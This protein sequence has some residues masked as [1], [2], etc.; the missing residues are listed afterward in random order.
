MARLVVLLPALNEAGNI[1]AVVK[2]VLAL[3]FPGIELS[4]LVVDD[5]SSDGTAAIARQAGAR[6][7]SHSINR[8]V[9]AAFRTGI[10]AVRA[11]G[12][13]YLAHMDSD[14]QILAEDLGRVIEPVLAGRCDLALGS[15]FVP[16][17][18]PPPNLAAWKS[19]VLT[20]VARGVGIVTGYR[21]TD[22]SCGVRCMNRKILDSVDPSFD[23]DYIQETLLQAIAAQARVEEIPVNPIYDIQPKRTSMSGR[24]FR[25][26]RRFLMLTAYGL[27]QFYRT[28]SSRWFKH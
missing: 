25:Y 26:G 8:G 21:L 28:R 11:E 12:V 27:F 5:G 3:S 10:H 23:Y 9:G 14:G 16:P 18:A 17:H 4:A 19:A 15:R 2:G 13:D 6:V 20:T 1:A 7:I 24:T 22:L